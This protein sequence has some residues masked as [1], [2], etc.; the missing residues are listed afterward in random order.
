[1]SCADFFAE[2][3]SSCILTEVQDHPRIRG[4]VCGLSVKHESGFSWSVLT[5]FRIS[6]RSFRLR[7]TSRQK[8]DFPLTLLM[9]L[10]L[11]EALP[12]TH[13]QAGL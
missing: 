2:S 5:A 3:S 6:L 7:L 11:T 9:S 1:M 10:N 8:L 12:A 4:R 13:S